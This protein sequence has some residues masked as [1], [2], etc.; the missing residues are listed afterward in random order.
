MKDLWTTVAS[1]RRALAGDVA[2]LGEAQW[3]TPSW[4]AGWSVEDVLAHLTATAS[5][6]PPTFFA[7]FAGSG[8]SF[9]RFAE[10]QIARYKGSTPAETLARFRAVET[11]TSA[12]PGPKL[13]WLGEVIVH[14][15]DIRRPLGIEHAH[16]V[17]AVRSVLDFYKGSNTLIG[18]KS[19]IAGVTLRATDT[20]WTHGEG[21]VVEGRA[22]DL[23]L[24]ATGRRAALDT[25]SGDGVTLMASRWG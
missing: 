16:P 17:E 7:R 4:C 15:E 24:A 14:S 22:I 8:F 11:S 5:L 3:V 13:S 19:R 25:L 10:R 20:D 9:P 18:A 6:T 2:G 21:P 12:P 23:L 1:E